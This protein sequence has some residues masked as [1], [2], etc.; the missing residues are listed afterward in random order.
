MKNSMITAEVE[1]LNSSA[2][3][4]SN[5]LQL[6]PTKE[7]ILV[8]RWS[9]ESL[10]RPIWKQIVDESTVKLICAETKETNNVNVMNFPNGPHFI[11]EIL[12][13]SHCVF[14]YLHSNKNFTRE[15]SFEHCSMRSFP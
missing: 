4:K 11:Y 2:N 1:I 12:P 10:Q 8:V 7:N 3:T 9:Q 5:L 6:L 13:I 14:E 15:H